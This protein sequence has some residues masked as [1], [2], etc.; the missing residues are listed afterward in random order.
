[1]TALAPTLQ[2]WF[3][4]RLGQQRQASPRT[5]AAYR[6]TFRLLL[7]YTKA[8]TGKAPSKLDL[9]DLDAELISGF[10]DHLEQQRGN[11]VPTRNTRLAA[12]HSFFQYASY[13][14]PE[15]LASINQVLAIPQ[16]LCE[17]RTPSFLTPAEMDALLAAPDRRTWT[18]RRDHT[19]LAVAL[20]TG[21][22]LCELI[23]LRCRDVELGTGAHLR[24]LGKGR[25]RRDT[26][27]APLTVKLVRVWMRERG[28]GPDDPLFPSSR[29]GPLSADAVQRLLAK[30]IETAG[31]ACP[32]LKTKPATPHALRRSF[33]MDMLRSGVD[34]VVI[35][36]WLGHEKLETTRTYLGA[37]PTIKE[38]ALQRTTPPNT[39]PGRFHP[40]D[41]L[42]AFLE[43]L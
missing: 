43:S 38:K 35:S 22:R 24:C 39:K 28:G 16:K 17:T 31:L 34:I 26:P 29:G 21:L 6:D 40:H 7:G 15:H 18:G 5:V 14:H 27:L 8:Q 37:D 13:C 25:K 2:A 36:M 19:L 30:H 42:L 11:S 9:G 41:T 20:G 4:S 12:I 1:V 23:G 10:L 3:T 32:S 33:A